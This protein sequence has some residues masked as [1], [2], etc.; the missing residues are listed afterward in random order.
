MNRWSLINAFGALHPQRGVLWQLVAGYGL[1]KA[2]ILRKSRRR[3]NTHTM[4]VHPIVDMTRELPREVP[5]EAIP[6]ARLRS[7][8]LAMRCKI[9]A[10]ARFV[11][12]SRNRLSVPEQLGLARKFFLQSTIPSN[13]Y[14]WNIFVGYLWEIERRN[15]LTWH[16]QSRTWRRYAS[17]V[18]SNELKT[19]ARSFLLWPTP[20]A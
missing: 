15:I 14:L 12:K 4:S 11:V 3:E 16:V 18:Y 2:K 1:L 8:M 7:C 9:S 20:F 5:R 17:W 10:N 6:W 13:K 19:P